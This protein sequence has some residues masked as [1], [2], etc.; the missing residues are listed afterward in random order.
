MKDD[1]GNTNVDLTALNGALTIERRRPRR[2]IFLSAG[3]L[4][5]IPVCHYYLVDANSII[6]FP[7]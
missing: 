3:G 1:S 6:G 5:Q 7:Y 4:V 2:S